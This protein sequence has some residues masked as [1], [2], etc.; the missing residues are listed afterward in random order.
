MAASPTAHRSVDPQ[1]CSQLPG[2]AFRRRLVRAPSRKAL[3]REH[4]G[5]SKEVKPCQL[6]HLNQVALAL[7]TNSAGL[8][9][10]EVLAPRLIDDRDHALVCLQAL[11]PGLGRCS[12]WSG[13]AW[14]LSTGI[15]PF[16][17]GSSLG[18]SRDSGTGY[19]VI[20]RRLPRTGRACRNGSHI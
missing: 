9:L 5:S 12:I 13:R 1:R 15:D 3:R 20:I 14:L 2:A 16:A 6:I 18:L 11:R 10:V 17:K 19:A 8:G 7:T 4:L